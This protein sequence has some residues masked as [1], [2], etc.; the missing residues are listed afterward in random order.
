VS[1]STVT[2][3]EQKTANDFVKTIV[4]TGYFADVTYGG[5]TGT[6]EEG[7]PVVISGV[8]LYLKDVPIE[9]SSEEEAAATEEVAE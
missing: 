6:G 8:E 1:I 3:P 5:Y 2:L 4:D 7:N 9:S